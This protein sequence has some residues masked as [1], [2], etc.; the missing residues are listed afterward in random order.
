MRAYKQGGFTLI[1]ALVALVI[2][3]LGMMA[4][5]TQVGRSAFT[6][7]YMR[8]KTFASWMASNKITEMSLA[9]RWPETGTSGGEVDFAGRTWRWSAEV[10][11]TQVPNLRRV[12]VTIAPVDSPDD[13]VHTVSGLLEPP[14]PPG[15]GQQ[16]W[17]APS[18]GASE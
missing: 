13:I 10:S 5:N 11:N 4:V 17:L 7:E 18:T 14:A 2:V 15:L 9:R 1:E 6:A 8:D 16:P 3:A 12:D